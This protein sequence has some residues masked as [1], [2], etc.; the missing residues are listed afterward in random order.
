M[1]ENKCSAPKDSLGA[2]K[3]MLFGFQCLAWIVSACRARESIQGT[4]QTALV[5]GHSTL[6]CEDGI[7]SVAILE[8]RSFYLSFLVQKSRV[9]LQC[10]TY[11]RALSLAQSL[12][13]AGSVGES[14]EWQ[15][16]PE[17]PGTRLCSSSVPNAITCPP[18]AARDPR[19]AVGAFKADQESPFPY[20][21]H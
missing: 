17:R 5:E 21:Q 6:L 4:W 1:S 2:L 20:A 18:T 3:Y 9:P 7:L 16:L 13:A 11:W 12:M 15:L 14:R 19:W 8:S 10:G